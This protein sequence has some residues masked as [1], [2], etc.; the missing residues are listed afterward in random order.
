MKP[1]TSKSITRPAGNDPYLS[2]L[3]EIKE[4]VSQAQVRAHL[5]VSR[6]LMLLYLISRS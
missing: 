3:A 4:R 5:A 2:L 1:H 6:E